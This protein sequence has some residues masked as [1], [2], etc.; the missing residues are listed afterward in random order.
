MT[1]NTPSRSGRRNHGGNIKPVCESRPFLAIGVPS[2]SREGAP[3]TGDVRKPFQ[4]Q[5]DLWWCALCLGVK[6][7]RRTRLGPKDKLVK[8]NDGGI[9]SSDP[10][11]IT[12]LE[13]LALAEFREEGL[14]NPSGTIQMASEY[15]ATGAKVIGEICVGAAEPTLT[16]LTQLP[17]Y[18]KPA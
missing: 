7:G 1:N 18:L 15:A 13:L 6:I 8:F 4:R 14:D 2:E 5:I 16:L 10:W 12:H 9:L 17:D 11:R 3:R